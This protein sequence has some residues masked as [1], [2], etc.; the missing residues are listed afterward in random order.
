M[1]QYLAD[2]EYEYRDPRRESNALDSSAR[3]DR[4]EGSEVT[5]NILLEYGQSD[6]D[7]RFEDRL[8]PVLQT[9]GEEFWKDLFKVA[10]AVKGIHR[11]EN[12]RDGVTQEY[13]GYV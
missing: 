10:D 12:R 7:E 3:P 13:Y 8:Q 11:F 1:I 9:E 6:L 5:H 2:Y 4:G